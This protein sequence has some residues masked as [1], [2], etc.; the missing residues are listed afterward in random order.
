[1]L[2]NDMLQEANNLITKEDVSQ[3]DILR[4]STSALAVRKDEVD[5]VEVLMHKIEISKNRKEKRRLM[6]EYNQR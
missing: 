5:E 6:A 1:M 2:L 4:G 3:L